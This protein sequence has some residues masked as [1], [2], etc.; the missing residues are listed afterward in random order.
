MANDSVYGLAASVW[1]RDA[2]RGE[3]V[4]RQVEAGVVVVNDAQVNYLATE[5]PMGGWKTSGL[6]YRHGKGGI[7]KFCRQ[8]SVMVT[9]FTPMKKDLW[10]LPYDKKATGLITK[11]VKFL[12]GRGKRD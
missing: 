2:A 9:R 4:A 6:G 3:Q 12:Y 8:Q 7:Q 10:M 5:L 1:T 11:M